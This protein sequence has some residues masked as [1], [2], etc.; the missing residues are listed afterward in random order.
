M[1]NTK[2][3][4]F[5]PVEL[6]NS[7]CIYCDVVKLGEKS[8]MP[9]DLLEIV[10]Q[11]INEYLEAHEDNDFQLIWHGGEPCMLG[12]DYFRKALEFQAR[13][14]KSTASRIKH[15]MQSNLT[16]INQELID[17]FKDMGMK[18]LGTSF[19]PLPGVRGMGKKIDSEQYNRK[20]FEG[21]NLLDKNNM[22]WG[23]IYVITRLSLE[24]P[25][26][27]FYYLTNLKLNAGPSFNTVKIFGK[28]KLSLSVTPE[29][30]ADWL[31][32]IYPVWYEHEDRF[33]AVKPFD[34]FTKLIKGENAP[35]GCE[36]SGA[37][38]YNWVYIGPTG[39]TSQCGRSGD[40]DILRYG[41]IRDYSLD[42]IFR[43][44][45]RELLRKRTEILAET[46]C[47]DCRFW[48][49]CH[50]GCPLDSY[51]KHRDFMHKY[52]HCR[53]KPLIFEKY[54]EPVTGLKA[55][56]SYQPHKIMAESS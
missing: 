41:N 44:E 4:I 22:G 42:E 5:K 3:I 14:C 31:G 13:Y 53:E 49:I 40:Y 2:V 20:F 56:F 32:A 26:E 50:G 24:M 15:D 39:E 28:D 8:I 48:N 35:L 7:N 10:F 1:K 37:C 6:C 30:V 12:V 27:I 23:I 55:D 21:I 25:L 11:K 43:N 16:M 45:Q 36:D 18:S 46:E 38:A 51:F 54:I 9:I 29:E 47:K 33:S 34:S 52:P 17:V 19:E